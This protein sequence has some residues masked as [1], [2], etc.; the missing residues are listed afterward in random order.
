MAHDELALLEALG[1]KRAEPDSSAQ[2][3]PPPS[4]PRATAGPSSQ[5]PPEPVPSSALGNS[6]TAVQRAKLDL[7]IE[8]LSGV[9]IAPKDRRLDRSEVASLATGFV[10]HRI[11]ELGP[12]LHASAAQ[13]ST[14]WMTVGVL[15]DKGPAKPTSNGDS[16]C[17]WKLTDLLGGGAAS[18]L[19]VFLFGEA[20]SSAWKEMVGSTFAVLNPRPLPPKDGAATAGAA[21]AIEKQQQLQRIGR[22]KDFGICKSERKDGRAC[23]MWVNTSECEHCEFHAAAALRAF[24][25]QNQPRRSGAAKPAAPP[26]AGI[27]MVASRQGGAQQ[28]QL[29]WQPC[30]GGGGGGGGGGGRPGTAVAPSA[31][32]AVAMAHGAARGAESRPAGS[33]RRQD[34]SANVSV[35]DAKK[36]FF[37]AGYTVGPDGS[38]VRRR[39]QLYF[40][41]AKQSGRKHIGEIGRVRRALFDRCRP[42]RTRRTPSRCS[43]RPPSPS[44][45]PRRARRRTGQD[46]S[47]R[48]P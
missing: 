34:Y 19:S 5:F 10:N 1:G 42:T 28:Q 2:P 17:I 45:A 33:A 44:L 41:A 32:A 8:P 35:S 3:P 14:P 43:A 47:A 48:R 39:A 18:T 21:V 40:L 11:G 9:R 23:S 15:V 36:A 37:D 22:A 12:V 13:Q 38:F 26:P 6:P 4:R 24:E 29:S 30:F 31:R 16:F 27:S 7:E 46:Q 20:F 25:R